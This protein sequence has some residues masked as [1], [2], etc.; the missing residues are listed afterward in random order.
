M[1]LTTE[2]PTLSVVGE[3]GNK[4]EEEGLAS[5]ELYAPFLQAGK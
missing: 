3:R 5:E 4:D 2:S 1:C